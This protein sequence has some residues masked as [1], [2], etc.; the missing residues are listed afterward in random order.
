MK[1]KNDDQRKDVTI[2]TDSCNHKEGTKKRVAKLQRVFSPFV[3]G[4]IFFS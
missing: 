1:Y 4:L 2:E 3:N